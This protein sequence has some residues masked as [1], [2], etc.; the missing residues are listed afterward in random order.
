ML[1]LLGTL[2]PIQ[3][4]VSC[5]SSAGFDYTSE[6]YLESRR[7]SDSR[8]EQDRARFEYQLVEDA[9]ILRVYRPANINAGG[10]PI[11]VSVAVRD[12]SG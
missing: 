8:R 6:A 5:F 3:S 7:L 10:T 11:S 9:A 12:R 2:S 1:L 4:L